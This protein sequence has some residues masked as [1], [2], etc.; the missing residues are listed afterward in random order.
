MGLFSK[1]SSSVKDISYGRF[2]GPLHA[3]ERKLEQDST[4]STTRRRVFIDSNGKATGDSVEVSMG[5]FLVLVLFSLRAWM[6]QVERDCAHPLSSRRVTWLSPLS[7]GRGPEGE[8]R[9]DLLQNLVQDCDR[10]LSSQT[11]RGQGRLP[12]PRF[13]LLCV[14][15]VHLVPGSKQGGAAGGEADL[16]RHS[17]LFFQDCTTPEDGGHLTPSSCST[18]VSGSL[19]LV[20]PSLPASRGR[21]PGPDSAETPALMTDL[22]TVRSSSP[23]DFKSCELTSLVLQHG[24]SSGLHCFIKDETALPL[25]VDAV[26]RDVAKLDLAAG[27][28]KHPVALVGHSLGG[29]TVCVALSLLLLF[30]RSAD[31]ASFSAAVSRTACQF[32]LSSIP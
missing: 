12:H 16:P 31:L 14:L 24:R 20:R 15:I 18:L 7:S 26:L 21:L 19:L 8:Q 5:A 13:V 25:A 17:V 4:V 27:K 3:D 6:D 29:W 23:P 32:F 1:S 10:Q 11:G 2:L 30:V 22:P 28:A 9:L